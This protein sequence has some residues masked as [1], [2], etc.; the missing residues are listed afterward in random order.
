VENLEDRSDRDHLSTSHP[1]L[2]RGIGRDR[3]ISID[4]LQV[5]T[6]YN[7]E[8]SCNIVSTT[9]YMV[10]S[11][12]PINVKSTAE[13]DV[14]SSMIHLAVYDSSFAIGCIKLYLPCIWVGARYMVFGSVA[15]WTWTKPTLGP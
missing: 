2:F 4:G 12:Q 15:A 10:L 13:N 7:R 5:F 6:G 14:R 11:C 8:Q 9:Q 1:A 3:S